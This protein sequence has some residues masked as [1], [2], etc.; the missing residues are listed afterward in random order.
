MTDVATGGVTE[1][2]HIRRGTRWLLLAPWVVT[3]ILGT[4]LVWAVPKA[5]DSRA[6][7]AR[8][9]N[10]AQGLNRE[11]AAV[12]SASAVLASTTTRL[13]EADAKLASLRQQMRTNAAEIGRLHDQVTRLRAE[14]ARL[15][16]PRPVFPVIGPVIG[17]PHIR[18][19]IEEPLP[20]GGYRRICYVIP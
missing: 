15:S 14:R 13:G 7:A 4:S 1:P 3:A 10:L 20:G 2:V 16:A 9:T 8:D 12:S 6:A 17:P 18:T 11:R 5:A 19:C